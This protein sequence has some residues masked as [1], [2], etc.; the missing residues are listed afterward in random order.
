MP[1]ELDE[2][3]SDTTD[4]HRYF[5]SLYGKDELSDG[6]IVIMSHNAFDE[7]K[8]FTSGSL[9]ADYIAEKRPDDTFVGVGVTSN[10]STYGRG[11][12]SKIIAMPGV[13][14]DIDVDTK[15]YKTTASGKQQAVPASIQEAEGIL[16]EMPYKPSLLVCSGGGL[17]AYWLFNELWYFDNRDRAKSIVYGWRQEVQRCFDRHGYGIDHVGDLAR[18]LRCPGVINSKHDRETYIY[19]MSEDIRYSPNDF[20]K[21]AVSPNTAQSTPLDGELNEVK[22]PGDV[23]ELLG[24]PSKLRMIWQQDE[25]VSP[26]NDTS[27]SGWD[28]ILIIEAIRQGIKDQNVLWAMLREYRDAHCD[29]PEKALKGHN[30]AYAKR[31]IG[32][33]FDVVGA[34]APRSTVE[35]DFTP[36]ANGP[37][38]DPVR[39]GERFDRVYPH[40][41]RY[42][43]NWYT[44]NPGEGWEFRS[45]EDVRAFVTRECVSL[46]AEEN[47]RAVEIAEACGKPPK[48]VKMTN[49]HINNAITYIQSNKKLSDSLELPAWVSGHGPCDINDVFPVQ[50]GLLDIKNRRLIANTPNFFDIGRSSCTFVPEAKCSF[51][52]DWLAEVFEDDSESIELLQEWMGYLISGKTHL[53]KMLFMGGAPRAGKG[54]IGQIMQKVVGYSR[55]C[56]PNLQ[57]L[58]HPF[59]LEPLMH[60]RF[61]FFGDVRPNSIQNSAEIVQTLLGWVGGDNFNINRK[62]RST[63]NGYRPKA[64]FALAFNNIPNL[65]E[66][67]S[68]LVSRIVYLNF[69]I[70]RTGTED[71]EL[72]RK[73]SAELSGILNWSLDGLE[74]LLKRGDFVNPKRSQH[75]M[76]LIA[77]TGC[78]I[79]RFLEDCCEFDRRYKAP[80]EGL[81]DLY[82]AWAMANGDAKPLNRVH[83]ARHLYAVRP[84]LT[85]G[86]H[87]DPVTGKR[88]RFY[89]GIKTTKAVNEIDFM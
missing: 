54:T 36:L 34:T 20:D 72:Q 46:A 44:W 75:A 26:P 73:I 14:A 33:A 55:S 8:Y 81:Y 10:T 56:T 58:A 21:F 6:R 51:W 65:R 30:E 68:A 47:A 78:P 28:Q 49:M 13:F 69:T 45:A 74:R 66:E 52:V 5:W 17:H 15:G 71:R 63:I 41:K 39:V 31:T 19:R 88:D 3:F 62:F 84:S 79:K 67:S 57:S 11:D 40:T 29:N 87:V 86:R 22:I 60:S 23:T 70:S 32:K 53:Q 61:A 82:H 27:Q 16:D 83:F 18:V 64:R 80:K 1:K 50:N 42:L 25:S 59:G 38:D 37:W 43:E 24:K 4:I 77:D 7:P 12:E 35:D 85:E 76:D 89:L 2:L 48:L 9:V